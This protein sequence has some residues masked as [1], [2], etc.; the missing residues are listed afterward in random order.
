MSEKITQPWVTR[1]DLR[2]LCCDAPVMVGDD[3]LC[4]KCGYPC[5]YRK[6]G[7]TPYQVEKKL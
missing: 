5:S 4:T 6:I 3:A 1:E 7:D 2:S